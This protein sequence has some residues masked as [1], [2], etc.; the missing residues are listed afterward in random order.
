MVKFW[1]MIRDQENELVKDVIYTSNLTLNMSNF[2]KML[3]EVAYQL[4]ISTPVVLLTHFKHFVKF[5]RIKF[6]PRDFIEAVD[7]KELVI[8]NVIE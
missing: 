6:I 3:Q 1:A 4:D 2:Q 8:E 5:N 7:F